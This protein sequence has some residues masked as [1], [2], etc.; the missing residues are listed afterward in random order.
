MIRTYEY[1]EVLSRPKFHFPSDLVK[2]IIDTFREK[3]LY[4][5]AEP[6]DLNLPDQKD[7][8]FY[9][10]VME[11]RKKENAYLVT[12]NIK[13]FPVKPFIVTPRI[14]LDIILQDPDH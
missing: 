2:V 1:R 14:M 12:G 10:V 6:L 5:D 3:G 11:E 4:I 8:V 9:E 13:H 7:L